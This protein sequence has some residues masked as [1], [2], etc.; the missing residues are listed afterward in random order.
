MK[1]GKGK[2]KEISRSV[3]GVL[4]IHD[5][6]VHSYGG[7]RFI[8]LHVEVDEKIPIEKYHKIADT[9][10]KDITTQMHAEVVT[11]VDPVSNTGSAVNKITDIITNV[12]IDFE[13]KDKFQDLRVM[14]EDEI[15][16]IM[17]EIP[18]PYN[19]T[20]NYKLE[21][22]LKNALLKEFHKCEIKVE[23]KQQIIYNWFEG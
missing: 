4:N 3:D 22:S 10:E 15:K 17:F 5:I 12:L 11:H 14:G 7:Q 2:I 6:I 9:V 13:F 1:K 21:K 19:Y 23:F 16:S 18:T 8:S 20:D